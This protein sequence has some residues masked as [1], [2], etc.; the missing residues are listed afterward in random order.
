ML[1][2]QQRLRQHLRLT[3]RQRLILRT[4]QLQFRRDL[5]GAL[6]NDT[7]S[8]KAVCPR[9][10]QK[11]TDL[12]IMQ[13]FKEDPRDYTTECPH[14]GHRFSPRLYRS[15]GSVQLDTAFFCPAQTLDQMYARSETPLEEFRT[16]HAA[17]YYSTILH[18]GG[19]KQAFAKIG[20][21]Y[22]HEAELDWKNRVGPFL[23]KMA[24]TVIAELVDAP[25]A[26]IRKLRRDQGIKA[27][28]KR[29]DL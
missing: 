15:T 11:L 8:P 18:F 23:G 10:F 14:C 27:Y 4:V 16:H 28:R 26:S 1:Q 7:F 17:V 19:L 21:T 3:Q 24:D 6:H 2:Q 20:L 22:A 13:G 9:C 12:E 29:D 5:V 25:V